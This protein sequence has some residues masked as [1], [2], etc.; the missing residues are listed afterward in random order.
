VSTEYD[1]LAPSGRRTL[2]KN[3]NLVVTGLIACLTII[4]MIILGLEYPP[5]L[6]TLI[7]T[8]GM[9]N[10]VY[11]ACNGSINVGAWVL[12]FIIHIG[13]AF[14]GF[15]NSGFG[16]SIILL[17][18]I[19][20]ILT[21]LLLNGRAAWISLALVCLTLTALLVLGLIGAIP[22]NQTRLPRFYLVTL[23]FWCLCAWYPP[24]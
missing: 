2:I 5:L 10:A 16:G 21:M 18:P 6:A 13:L 20:P 7:V 9:A 19:I 4:K 12:I 11:I 1:V 14:A 8:A 3:T 23:L 15:Y 17:A 24:G 22:E